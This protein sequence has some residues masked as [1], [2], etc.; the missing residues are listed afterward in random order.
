MYRD[1]IALTVY[2]F[3][4]HVSNFERIENGDNIEIDSF[5]SEQRYV[6]CTNVMQKALYDLRAM[7]MKVWKKAIELENLRL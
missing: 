6:N 7:L 2:L 1:N 3:N 4:K 5:L